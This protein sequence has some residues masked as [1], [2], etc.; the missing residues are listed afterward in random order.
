M[1]QEFGTFVVVI[2]LAYV[3]YKLSLLVEAMGDK[4]EGKREGTADEKAGGERGVQDVKR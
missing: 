4:I 3:V 2:L 1:L